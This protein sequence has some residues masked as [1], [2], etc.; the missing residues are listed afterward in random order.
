MIHRPTS[1]TVQDI[2]A[3]F[4]ENT[5]RMPPQHSPAN[6][7]FTENG[8]VDAAQLNALY[9]FIGWDRY[10]SRTEAKTL[11]MLRRYTARNVNTGSSGL[12]VKRLP[13]ILIWNV[14]PMLPVAE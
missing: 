3:V 12:H 11:E 2:S 14:A 1:L 9:R 8:T 5:R 13:Q 10:H 4:N 6:V 7:R